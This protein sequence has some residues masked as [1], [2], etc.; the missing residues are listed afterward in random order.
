VTFTAPHID[1]AATSPVIALTAGIVVVLMAGALTSRSQRLV[2]SALSL[3]TLA[4][5]AGLAIWQ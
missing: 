2:V 1:Y 5:A 4:A 3:T